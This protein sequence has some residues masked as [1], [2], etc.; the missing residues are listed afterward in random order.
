MRKQNILLMGV[1]V[2]FKDE[3]GDEIIDKEIIRKK[4]NRRELKRQT[5]LNPNT[6]IEI[7]RK[8]KKDDHLIVLALDKNEL[9]EGLKKV[10]FDSIAMN[11][12]SIEQVGA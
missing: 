1:K 11:L 9:L 12:D 8:T 2:I 4:L 6:P 7:K 5:I 3:I 10:R